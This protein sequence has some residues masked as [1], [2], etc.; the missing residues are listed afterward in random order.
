MVGITKATSLLIWGWWLCERQGLNDVL[1]PFNIYGIIYPNNKYINIFSK[2]LME[3]TDR[4]QQ[5]IKFHRKEQRN[6]HD[7]ALVQ[8][9]FK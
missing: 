1:K 5:E 8:E 2:D 4:I 3:C 9:I 7:L 6:A